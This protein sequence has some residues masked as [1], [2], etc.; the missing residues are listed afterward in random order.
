M[1]SD[2][3]FAFFDGKDT[4]KQEKYKRKTCFSLYFARFVLS[5]SANWK[6]KT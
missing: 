1:P 3:N 6:N 2:S 4:K 5:L